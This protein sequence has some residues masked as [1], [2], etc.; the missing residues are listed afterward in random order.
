MKKIFL[1][2]FIVILGGLIFYWYQYRPTQIRSACNSQA[3]NFA[4]GVITLYEH[5]YTKCL[6][7]KGLN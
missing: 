5:E 4:G 6:H 2:L 7:E 1:I 3:T